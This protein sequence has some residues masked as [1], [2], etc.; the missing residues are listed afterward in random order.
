MYSSDYLLK[1]FVGQMRVLDNS[2]VSLLCSITIVNKGGLLTF[3]SS[4]PVSPLYWPLLYI[5][6]KTFFFV[7]VSPFYDKRVKGTKRKVGESAESINSFQD[8]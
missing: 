3:P 2:W 8:L 6:L 7:C 4:V 1:G 5:E